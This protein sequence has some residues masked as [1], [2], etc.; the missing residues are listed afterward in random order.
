MSD[1]TSSGNFCGLSGPSRCF[2]QISRHSL[3]FAMTC[4]SRRRRSGS[5]R[6][7]RGRPS[8]PPAAWPGCAVGAA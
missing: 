3:V 1:T 2:I 4:A 7:A 6:R 5:A 8:R